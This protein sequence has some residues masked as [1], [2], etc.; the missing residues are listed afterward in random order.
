MVRNDLYTTELS[1]CNKTRVRRRDMEDQSTL[2]KISLRC[3]S[4]TFLLRES[5]WRTRDS[6]IGVAFLKLEFDCKVS[7]NRGS[8]YKSIQNTQAEIDT[9]TIK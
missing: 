3:P 4:F 1:L 5:T 7:K 6:R 8:S 2:P 9:N